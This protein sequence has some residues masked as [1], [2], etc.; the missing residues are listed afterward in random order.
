MVC[1]RRAITEREKMGLVV[2]GQAS[3]GSEQA[4][5]VMSVREFALPRD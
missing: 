4:E 1:R 3:V 5:S 2:T